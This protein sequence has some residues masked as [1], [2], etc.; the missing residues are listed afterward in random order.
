M[1]GRDGVG[2]YL[3]G[4]TLALV[5]FVAALSRAQNAAPDDAA[6]ADAPRLEW[7]AP[8]DCPA[9]DEVLAQIATLAAQDDVS[10]SRF[11]LIR[12]KIEPSGA[13]FRLALE[14]VGRADVRR[15]DMDSGSCAELA[16]AAAVS[17]VLAHRSGDEGF[18]AS[19]AA[20]VS[21]SSQSPPPVA[22]AKDDAVSAP[23]SQA[24]EEG[25]SLSLGAEALLDPATLGSVAVGAAIGFELR[26]GTLGAR[27][28]AAGFPSVTTELGGEQ[29]VDVG[30]WTGGLSA[31]QRWGR[32]FDTCALM[33]LGHLSAKG[34]SLTGAREASDLWAAPGLSVGLSSS[35]FDG[36][37]IST[38]LSAFHPLVRGTF[39]VDD[40]DVV[41]R[42]PVVGFRAS[43]GID[44][45]LL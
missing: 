37:G 14:F 3:G 32:G 21:S 24:S 40:S 7:R 28:Y 17:I 39:R 10:W 30:L 18:A 34:V 9:H 23:A 6:A 20:T 27:L 1:S 22:L 19:P 25:A 36:F 12:A 4:T 45:P 44:V 26:F 35:P 33:E 16:Q 41:H 43:L 31:C 8:D 5:S 15:R 29:G 11:Q 2:R 38:R 13:R 42:V